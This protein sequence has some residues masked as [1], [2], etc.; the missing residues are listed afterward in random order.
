GGGGGAGG[1]G[2]GE[3]WGGG[4][5]GGGRGRGGGE[6][7]GAGGGGVAMPRG[8][9]HALPTKPQGAF[10]VTTAFPGAGKIFRSPAASLCRPINF[11]RQ[12]ASITSLFGTRK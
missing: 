9:S 6:G 8:M 2:G 11:S 12:P 7:W 5:R 10:Y 3:R 1:R 4:G